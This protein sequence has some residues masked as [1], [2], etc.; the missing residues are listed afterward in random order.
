[1]RPFSPSVKLS[2]TASYLVTLIVTPV[3]VTLK[4]QL[5]CRPAA[6]LAVQLTDVVPSGK[7]VPGARAHVTATGAVPPLV[8]GRSNG[9]FCD[10][11]LTPRIVTSAGQVICGGFTTG[12]GPVLLPPHAV[13][14]SARVTMH[15]RFMGF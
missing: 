6:S 11:A 8:V 1:M 3:S 13:A 4:A 10:P 12:V 5:D 2:P 9:T 7:L 14:S 15:R